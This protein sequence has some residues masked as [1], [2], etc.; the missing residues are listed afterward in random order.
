VKAIEEAHSLNIAAIAVGADSS[1]VYSG[2]RD[3]GIKGW[4]WETGKTIAEF[5]APRNIVTTMEC[6]AP[7]SGS[8]LLFQGS[9]DLCVR[10]WDPKSKAKMPAMHI[11]GYVYFPTSMAVHPGGQYLATGC[12]GFDSVGCEVKIWDLRKF[13]TP[14]GELRGHSH[15]VTAVRYINTSSSSSSSSGSSSSSASL[16]SASK[17]GSI[18]VWQSAENGDMTRTATVPAS[19]GR[20]FTSIAVLPDSTTAGNDPQVAL[21]A[22]DGSLSFY[23]VKSSSLE[24]LHSTAPYGSG[25]GEGGVTD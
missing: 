9:E 11:T 21:G 14:V 8:S 16:I 18:F 23:K 20:N 5:S 25:E 15:D 2:S 24:S 13:S 22:F 17:D 7:S 1:I 19:F 4:E 3:Y 10:A 12:K 6:A